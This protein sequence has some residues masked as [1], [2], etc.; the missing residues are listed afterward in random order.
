MRTKL[1]L[2]IAI[3][4]VLVFGGW[5]GSEV[6]AQRVGTEVRLPVEGYDPRDLLSGHYVRFRLVAERE[7]DA[8]A[9]GPHTYCLEMQEAAHHVRAVRD[10]GDTCP[11]YI[12][13]TADRFDI[14]RFYV[15]ER[16]ADSVARLPASDTTYLVARVTTDGRIHPQH[17]VVDGELVK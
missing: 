4:D 15:D 14:D 13:R 1:L 5:I 6:H 12:T 3:A 8:L 17:L 9:P 10:V 11:L 16:R 7:A 2:A